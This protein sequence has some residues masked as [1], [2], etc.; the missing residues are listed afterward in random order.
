VK[1]L[2]EIG[3][4]VPTVIIMLQ[5]SNKSAYRQGVR[6][7][8]KWSDKGLDQRLCE[9]TAGRRQLEGKPSEIMGEEGAPAA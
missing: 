7:L 5:D 2:P 8:K 4:V 9:E 6:I 3:G 1:F